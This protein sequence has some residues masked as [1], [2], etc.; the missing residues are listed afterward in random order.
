MHRPSKRTLGEVADQVAGALSRGRDIPVDGV[1]GLSEAGPSQVAF[2]ADRRYAAHLSETR[3]AAVLV[4]RDWEGEAPCPVLRVDDPDSAIDRL[5]ALFAPA[6][7]PPEPG[8]HPSAVLAPDAVLGEGVS[9]GAGTVIG[10]GVAIGAGTVIDANVTLAEGVRIGR[11][12][13]LYPGVSVREFCRLGDRV[14]LHNGVVI[15]SDG[16]GYHVSRNADGSPRVAKIPQRGIVELGDDVE[17][18]ANSTVDRA[19]FG[20]TRIGRGVKIDNLVQVAHN[21]TIGDF[22]GIAAQ[23]GISGSTHVGS[24][25]MLWGQVG[26][27]GHLRIGDGAEIGA[28]SGVSKD[29]PPGEF[30]VGS[31]AVGRRE[32]VR[33]LT[34]PREIERLKKRLAALEAQCKAQGGSE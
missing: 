34:V 28:Q 17:I 31:P 32:F 6:P 15:G 13:R 21:V 16:F 30:V 14:I 27:A 24:G 22:S 18:G 3:A 7:A 26:L 4:P 19:R 20:C 11:D 23:V 29:V 12:S 25:V 9:V 5:A 8:V 1:A 33:S 10:R 2:L